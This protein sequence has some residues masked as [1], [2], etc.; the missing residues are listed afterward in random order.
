MSMITYTHGYSLICRI[1]NVVCCFVLLVTVIEAIDKYTALGT[2]AAVGIGLA[3]MVPVQSWILG[4]L[5]ETLSAYLYVKFTLRTS[6][7]FSEA[8]G[9]AFLFEPN[10]TG[11]WW[12]MKDVRKL[13]ADERKARLLSL[14]SQASTSPVPGVSTNDQSVNVCTACGMK[15][16]GKF[17]N[18]QKCGARF[19]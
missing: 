7:S 11:S 9:L 14:A 6:I 2:W 12:P 4:P 19:R 16:S 18:C 3:V 17:S 8:K 15:H 10:E 1:L 5:L 13:P